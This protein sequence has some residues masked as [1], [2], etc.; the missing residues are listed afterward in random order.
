VSETNKATAET[1]SRRGVPVV[2]SVGVVALVAGLVLGI[3]GLTSFLHTVQHFP[4]AQ[5]SIDDLTEERYGLAV[6]METQRFNRVVSSMTVREKICQMLIVTPDALSGVPEI[7]NPTDLLKNGLTRCPVGGVIMF[8]PNITSETQIRGLTTGLQEMTE[9]PLFIA[10]DEEGG[11]VARL[12]SKLGAHSVGPMLSYENSGPQVAYDNALTLAKA[13]TNRG[14]NTAF[15]P[16]ADVLSNP[17][18]TVI[19]DRA[20]SRN[21]DTAAQLIPEAVRGFHDG[22]VVCSVKHFPGHGGTTEDSH[23]G[24][25]YVNRTLVELTGGE[26][27]PFAAGIDAGVDM[28]MLGHLIVPTVDS[29]PATLSPAMVTGVLRGDLGFQGVVITDALEM[30]AVSQ[31]FSTQEVA[32]KTVE[33]GVDILL[34]PADIEATVEALVVAVE[35]GTITEDRINE[36]VERILRLK[37]TSGI[38]TL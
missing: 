7:K 8:G 32:V 21:F 23:D 9:I 15:S 19:G 33:A 18:N 22:G 14:F 3:S 16:V 11:Q 6:T 34:V 29:L 1:R 30:S 10:V 17:R 24:A 31:G 2:V 28:V 5:L 13:L 20:Y 25:A 27:K 4:A 26:F 37:I 35:S 38:M 12:K 36:S